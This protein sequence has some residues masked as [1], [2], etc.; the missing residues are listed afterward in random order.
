MST[1]MSDY[2]LPIIAYRLAYVLRK[3]MDLVFCGIID[4]TFIVRGDAVT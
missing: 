3:F 2:R 4:Q 1:S